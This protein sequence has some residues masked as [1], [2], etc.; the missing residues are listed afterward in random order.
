M[1]IYKNN[2][3]TNDLQFCN[4]ISSFYSNINVEKK[5]LHNYPS[6]PERIIDT[7]IRPAKFSLELAY[8]ERDLNTLIIDL[9]EA[10]KADFINLERI[11]KMSKFKQYKPKTIEYI[12]LIYLTI[13]VNRFNS[14]FNNH[15]KCVIKPGADIYE[16]LINTCKVN[17]QNV[18]NKYIDPIIKN[19]ISFY[20]NALT[21][22][23]D[24]EKR[25]LT[26]NKVIKNKGKTK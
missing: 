8:L 10:K 6:L 21:I 5:Y 15:E 7:K 2:S 17:K 3:K 12:I 11:K 19:F 25:I 16:F 18:W 26:L 23:Y 20:G 24:R 1:Y 13:K 14:K 22:V 4:I 9:N